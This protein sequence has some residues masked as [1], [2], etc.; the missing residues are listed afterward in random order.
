[1]KII[2]SRKGFDST[3][4]EIA[5]PIMSDGRLLSL[6]I[7][8]T[9]RQAEGGEV[10]IPYH[11]LRFDNQPLDEIIHQLWN[12]HRRPFQQENAH[13]D[14]DLDPDRFPPR[15]PGW[16]RNFGQQGN[17]QTHLERCGVGKDD[18]FL[19]FGWFKQAELRDGV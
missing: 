1:M 16:R 2:L 11:E 9:P 3:T 17:A 15:Q 4:A 13:L 12:G 7:P 5:S 14:P 6:P 10:G 19:F 18:L 8:V